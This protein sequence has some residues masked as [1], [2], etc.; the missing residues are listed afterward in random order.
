MELKYPQRL[1]TSILD[2]DRLGMVTLNQSLTLSNHFNKIYRSA[3][4]KLYFLN[5]LK[6]SVSHDTM[7]KIYTGIILSS[8]LLL[9][10]NTVQLKKLKSLDSRANKITI[11]PV[12][13][14]RKE[15]EKCSC[16]LVKKCVLGDICKLLRVILK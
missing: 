3:S 8:P 1:S 4:N 6:A 16:L 9:K 15:I 10:M 2:Q 14:I 7:F 5:L 11:C 13:L 12:P